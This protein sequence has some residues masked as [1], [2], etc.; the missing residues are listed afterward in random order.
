MVPHSLRA[1]KVKNS[2]H[3]HCKV[4]AVSYMSR[5]CL[6]HVPYAPPLLHR[7]GSFSVSVGISVCATVPTKTLKFASLALR[8]QNYI[9]RGRYA[10]IS[11]LYQ[12]AA[13]GAPPAPPVDPPARRQRR[14][15]C[16]LGA[17]C[18][19]LGAVACHGGRASERLMSPAHAEV[20]AM[21]DDLNARRV[22]A[23]IAHE[24]LVADDVAELRMRVAVAALG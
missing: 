10:P 11:A 8:T 6:V 15:T 13:G 3:V 7:N 24:A 18:P 23:R 22:H 1:H 21:R 14:A 19:R 12:R 5:T 16:P 2:N 20:E 9:G 4:P 17:R